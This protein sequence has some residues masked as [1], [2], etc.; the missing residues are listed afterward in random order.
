MQVDLRIRNTDLTNVLRSYAERRLR[1]ALSR[2]GDRAGHV[3][4]TVSELKSADHG[5]A[6]NCRISADIRPFGQV[7][8]RETDPD[9]YAAIDRAA[10]RIGRLF[11]SRLGRAKDE[12]QELMTTSRTRKKMR[13]K[14]ASVAQPLRLLRPRPPNRRFRESLGQGQKRAGSLCVERSNKRREGCGSD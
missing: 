1:F 9:L 6:T 12:V 13:K 4:V 7:A 11:T 2:F 5:I 3:V 10:G 14:R 8:A